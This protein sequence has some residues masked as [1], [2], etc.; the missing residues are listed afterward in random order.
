[1]LAFY[2]FALDVL[3]SAIWCGVNVWFLTADPTDVVMDT[4]RT[5]HMGLLVHLIASWQLLWIVNDAMRARYNWHPRVRRPMFAFTLI[6]DVFVL[7][8]AVRFLP[9]VQESA[10]GLEV[11][12]STLF[13]FTSAMALLFQ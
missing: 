12:I 1:M 6:L 8:K 9:R 7:V 13:C 11:A 5:H 2:L 4:F 3:T 10:W